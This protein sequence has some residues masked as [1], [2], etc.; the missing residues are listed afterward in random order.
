MWRGKVTT[1]RKESRQAFVTPYFII[2]ILG[3]SLILA[4]LGQFLLQD[5]LQQA[6]NDAHMVHIVNQQRTLSQKVSTFAQSIEASILSVDFQTRQH[7]KETLSSILIQWQQVHDS[8]TIRKSDGE[9]IHL[10]GSLE[11][12]YRTLLNA[13]YTLL[14]SIN[15]PS[16]TSHAMI[17]APVQSILHEEP[18]YLRLVNTL[19]TRYQQESDT[20]VVYLPYI[21]FIA[22]GGTA[23]V[24][25]E[26]LCFLF[27]C[28]DRCIASS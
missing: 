27:I 20:R 12:H 25:G 2:F 1:M 7:Y 18:T 21:D 15:T 23:I 16:H 26:C 13:S 10:L 6:A 17:T 3:L 22:F 11:P 4:L 19:I 8:N 24:I 9:T 14:A 28:R 5:E